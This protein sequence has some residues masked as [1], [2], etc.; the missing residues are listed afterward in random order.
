MS[1]FKVCVVLFIGLCA[2]VHARAQTYLTCSDSAPPLKGDRGPPGPAGPPG[3]KGPKGDTGVTVDLEIRMQDFETRL[4]KLEGQTCQGTKVINGKTWY[5]PGNGYFYF[6]I[7]KDMRYKQAK[8]QCGK[9]QATLAVHAPRNQD[10]MKVLRK[11]ITAI[12]EEDYWIGL[13]DIKGEGNFVWEDGTPLKD[14]EANWYKGE[15]NNIRGEDCVGS[16]FRDTSRWNDYPCS[17]RKLYALC[18]RQG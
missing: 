6:V 8:A 16:N 2:V 18:E 17:L 1:S 7:A 15:P 4:A 14:S 11:Q 10:V 5:G 3:A 12:T 9:F 13:T